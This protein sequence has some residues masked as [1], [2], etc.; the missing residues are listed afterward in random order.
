MTEKQR[1]KSWVDAGV[2]VLLRQAI[3]RKKGYDAAWTEIRNL[4]TA[5]LVRACRMVDA[6]VEMESD[7][8]CIKAAGAP[9]IP[10]GGRDLM[11]AQAREVLEPKTARLFLLPA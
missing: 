6:D 2:R 10:D 3:N 9:G 4:T 5:D 7:F 8:W 11:L 1:D